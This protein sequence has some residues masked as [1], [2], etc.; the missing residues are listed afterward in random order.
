MLLTDSEPT[1]PTPVTKDELSTRMASMCLEIVEH[2]IG[3]ICTTHSRLSNMLAC[4]RL[5][6][7]FYRQPAV[8]ALREKMC[9]ELL[10]HRATPTRKNVTPECRLHVN[11][12]R[13]TKKFSCFL[14]RFCFCFRKPTR[15]NT[16]RAPLV[17]KLLSNQAN[18]YWCLNRFSL[19][20]K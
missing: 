14:A 1:A 19:T 8:F 16:R 12:A 4:S 18:G 13:V 3:L 2:S 6:I 5:F 20:S 15:H 17:E 11:S 9:E 10:N 7:Y